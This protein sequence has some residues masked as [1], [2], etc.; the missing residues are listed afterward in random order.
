[1]A[2]TEEPVCS[3]SNAPKRLESY[4][5]PELQSG[6]PCEGRE[7]A[8]ADSSAASQNGNSAHDHSRGEANGDAGD[9]VAVLTA[10]V[11]S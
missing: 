5:L 8:R 6:Q 11:G 7:E 2:I 3:N 10:K 4:A 9:A 1:M